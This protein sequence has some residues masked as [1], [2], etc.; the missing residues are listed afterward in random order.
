[1]LDLNCTIRTIFGDCTQ[2]S[3]HGGTFTGLN[4][5]NKYFR[6]ILLTLQVNFTSVSSIVKLIA[7]VIAS[8]KLHRIN[9]QNV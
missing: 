9:I 3:G 5:Y 2:V 1:M 6:S 8:V 7:D 4:G